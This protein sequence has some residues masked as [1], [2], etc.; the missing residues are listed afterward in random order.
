MSVNA[1]DAGK[2]GRMGNVAIDIGKKR[3]YIVVEQDGEIVR[4]GY[5]DTTADG[6]REYLS[7]VGTPYSLSRQ[8]A[9]STGLQTTWNRMAEQ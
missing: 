4:E 2:V 8:A 5:V 7:D 3:S 9:R 1:C 6:L